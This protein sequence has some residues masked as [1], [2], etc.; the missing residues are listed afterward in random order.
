MRRY[1]FRSI[2]HFSLLI[3]SLL[4]FFPA[5]IPAQT[6]GQA[7]A[8]VAPLDLSAVRPGPVAVERKENALL[9]R[10]PD[11]RARQWTAEFSL[12]PARPLVTSIGVAGRT[13]LERARPLYWCT[14]GKRRGGWDEFFDRPWTHPDGFRTF[15]GVF[16]LRSANVRTIGDRVVIHFDGLKL[17]IFEGGIAF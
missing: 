16:R 15:T 4:I 3:L 13:V 9:I 5:L 17:G 1:N 14:T 10:W 6:T 7:A 8:Q 11:E 2:Q 12:D